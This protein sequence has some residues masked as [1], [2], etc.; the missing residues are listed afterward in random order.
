VPASR[1]EICDVCVS[2]DQKA[3]ACSGLDVVGRGELNWMFELLGVQ[4]GIALDQNVLADQFLELCE[5]IPLLA[6][7]TLTGFR[8]DAERTSALSNA[9]SSAQLV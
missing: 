4:C 3:G 9:S 6:L 5:P 2:A 1:S 8:V 7:R